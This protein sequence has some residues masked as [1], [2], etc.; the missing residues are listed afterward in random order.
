MEVGTFDVIDS[1][2]GQEIY[3]DIYISEKR[4][5]S[6]RCL[7]MSMPKISFYSVRI[8]WSKATSSDQKC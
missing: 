8:Q 6:F 2:M 7:Y 1:T 4:T 3:S 5:H